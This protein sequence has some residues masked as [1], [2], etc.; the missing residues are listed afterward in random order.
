M[1]SLIFFIWLSLTVTPI[2]I[3]IWSEN[4]KKDLIFLRLRREVTMPYKK[5]FCILVFRTL[6]CKHTSFIVYTS[7][8]VH[9]IH[10]ALHC[11]Y[12]SFGVHLIVH[13]IYFTCTLFIVHT[14]HLCYTSLYTHFSQC[15]HTSLLYTLL[16]THFTLFDTFLYIRSIRLQPFHSSYTHF[17]HCAYTSFSV[18]FIVHTHFILLYTP[19]YTHLIP[20]TLQFTH[21]SFIVHF[22]VH[23]F[24]PSVHFIVHTLH[25]LYTSTYSSSDAY[26]I[27]LST[28][29]YIHFVNCN[30]LYTYL[31]KSHLPHF[32]R[33]SSCVRVMASSIL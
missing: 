26:F 28:L 13:F 20:C 29:P 23:T 19:T 11:T 12:T 3:A 7:L 25:S 32:L 16:H 30:L 9:F 14:F 21:P 33:K 1:I 8:C 10:C 5:H 18:L 15:A 2:L 22:I 31:R 24:A 27:D 4:E 6:H 17:I